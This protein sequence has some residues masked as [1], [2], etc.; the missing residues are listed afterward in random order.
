[1]GSLKNLPLDQSFEQLEIPNGA[2]LVLLGQKSFTWDLNYKGSNIQLLNNSLTANKK[3]E[4]DYETV[5]GTIGFSSGNGGHSRHYWEIKLD[6]F[7]DMED[8]YVGIARRNVDLHL[9]AWDTGSFWGW[10]CAGYVFSIN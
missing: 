4:I 3:Y 5:L 1:M 6:T 7:V 9:R 8:I 2:Q 10:I